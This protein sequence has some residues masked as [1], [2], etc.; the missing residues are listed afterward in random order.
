VPE[1][2][3]CRSS[4]PEYGLLQQ[5]KKNNEIISGVWVA[6]PGSHL[7]FAGSWFVHR[8]ECRC[9]D[10]N[11][12]SRTDEYPELGALYENEEPS[13]DLQNKLTELLATPFVDNT[14]NPRGF[15]HVN[16]TSDSLRIATWNIER[17]LEFDAI[18]AALT[19]D[20]RFFRRLAPALRSTPF[21]LKTIL[22]QAQRLSKAGADLWTSRH[23]NSDCGEELV[24]VAEILELISG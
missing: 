9:S 11:E 12:R 24:T 1:P 21:D 14:L 15:K 16:A 19:N 10:Q 18:K 22:D 5:R 2:P 3:V 4:L 6:Q 23:C 7:A 17:G 13:R 8:G 20:R